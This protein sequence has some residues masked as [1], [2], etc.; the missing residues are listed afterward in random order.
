MTV[1]IAPGKI[2]LL[3]EH[4]VIYGKPAISLA[5][6]LK[7]S[8]SI[9][10]SDQFLVNAHLIN[11]RRDTY[12]KKAIDMFWDGEPLSITTFSHI[13]SASGL[14]SSAAI[15]TATI[16][17]LLAMKG[18]NDR[19]EIAKKSFEVEYAVQGMASPNDT[20]TCT[21][22]RGIMVWNE[23]KDGYIWEISKN[24]KT[25]YIYPFDVPDIKIIV[26]FT[27]TKSKTSM[28]V[29]KV[30]K[31]V[32]H[33]SFARELLDEMASLVMGGLDAIKR[34]DIVELGR[35]MNND[36]KILRT[37]GASTEKIEKMVGEAIKNGAYGA[38]LTGAGGGGSVIAIADAENEERIYRAMKKVGKD[39]YIIT[40]DMEGVKVWND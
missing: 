22:G 33:S 24:N 21:N 7:A 2:I 39:A 35:I 14:G 9:E 26:G 38:K 36:H 23:K 29:K 20:S 1:A 10:R 4:G 18:V 37:L 12:I 11:E 40:P 31:F 34:N 17:A 6:S 30:K 19:K 27:G 13:P 28:M 25:W 3:G 16:A 8:V 32:E 15:T 5:I